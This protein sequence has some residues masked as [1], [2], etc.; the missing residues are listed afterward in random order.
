MYT[1]LF[2]SITDST[3]WGEEDHTRIVWITML[4]M[5]D[6]N[7]YVAA[8]VPGLAS[9]ARV[10]LD[11]T[12]RALSVLSGPD[13]WS[14]SK[15]FDGRRIEEA[16]GGWSIMNY[17]KYAKIRDEEERKEYMRNYMRKRR[18]NKTVSNVNSV[19]S[20]KPRL[21]HT[22]ADTD[23]NISSGGDSGQ[24]SIPVKP[25]PPV[26]K[27]GRFVQNDFDERDQ[28]ILAK[29]KKDVLAKINAAVGTETVTEDQFMSAVCEEAGLTPQ[30][31]KKLEEQLKW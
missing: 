19:N 26:E 16:A 8:S 24:G 13:K 4:A 30:R 23:T 17:T 15:E 11:K 20:S 5:A 18:V 25:P 1:K 3:I 9:R 6:K 28:R 7:G 21:A 2:S 27:N 31:V 14:R 10:S 29:A 22:D 12:V